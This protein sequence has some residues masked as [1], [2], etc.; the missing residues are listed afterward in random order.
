MSRDPRAIQR[1]VEEATTAWRPRSP[2]GD[3]LVHPA[4]AD[5]D[6]DARRRVHE[7]TSRS[8]LLEAALDPAGFSS[9][10][11]AVL[12]RIRGLHRR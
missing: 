4:W 8:R 10:V 7:E 5:L 1:L 11:W 3:V 9:T 12:G 6:D 2:H